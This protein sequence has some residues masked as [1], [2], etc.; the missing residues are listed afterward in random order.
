V[1]RNKELDSQ[2]SD[3]SCSGEE[4]EVDE[5]ETC[6]D[7][8]MQTR[9]DQDRGPPLIY[10]RR[11]KAGET[12]TMKWE[13]DDLVLEVEKLRGQFR[14]AWAL[15]ELFD[16]VTEERDNLLLKA[17]VKAE[18]TGNIK[19]ERD[20]L[21][22]ETE[23][24]RTQCDESGKLEERLNFL[25]QECKY[26]T[27]ER[28]AMRLE[29]QIIAADKDTLNKVRDVLELETKNHLDQSKA[30]ALLQEKINAVRIQCEDIAKE[31]NSFKLKYRR[32]EADSS[33][34]RNVWEALKVEREKLRAKFKDYNLI[35]EQ[36]KV[37]SVQ[38][39]DIAEERDSFNLRYL[40]SEA[41]IKAT[42]NAVEALKVETEE[43]RAQFKDYALLEKQLNTVRQQCEDIKKER[44]IFILKAQKAAESKGIIMIE[45]DTLKL[46]IENLRAKIK[47]ADPLQK[48]LH[49]ARLLCDNIKR[50][51][52]FYELKARRSARNRN[53]TRDDIDAL[54][55]VAE[56]LSAKRYDAALQEEQ[57]NAV[58]E[59]CDNITKERDSL[60]LE[61]PHI[62]RDTEAT[63]EDPV[64]D[65]LLKEQ[66]NVEREDCD[67]IAKE[68]VS[69]MLED[70]QLATDREATVE[71]SE[72]DELLE[73]EF[74][75]IREDCNNIV[76]EIESLMYE[77]NEMPTDRE[78]TVE[79][80]VED[81]LLEEELNVVSEDGDSIINERDSLMLE[82]K[83]MATD[84]EA[85]VE[86]WKMIHYWKSN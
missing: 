19:K 50:E 7:N 75:I 36:L 38:C 12:E 22:L 52:D 72:D 20:A 64:G 49:S 56:N 78:A 6:K 65:A 62:R 35:K 77:D 59:D 24:L 28:D 57:L 73:V 79:D 9:M 2:Y 67:S 53:A 16:K 44:N 13:R 71:D 11:G 80:P 23:K 69:L 21:K 82:V 33:D 42:R 30:A 43:L 46:E 66:L 68:R 47:D 76:K 54:K 3:A 48:Q 39:G 29:A 81:A 5:G 83:H 17:E 25:I 15:K 61:A 58:R 34:I 55:L 84:R 40:R 10:P 51:R 37:L 60:I 31:R 14:D 74:D 26:I 27:K 4:D 32:S 41:N 1:L 70:K 18:I 45:R 85:T 8:I 86:D 63:V